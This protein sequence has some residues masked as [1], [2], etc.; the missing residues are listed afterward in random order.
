M[1]EPISDSHP[2]EYDVCLSFSGFD[3]EY[4]DDV[5]KALRRLGVSCF[6]DEFEWENIWGKNLIDE[7][8][9]IYSRSA[10]Y[11][12]IFIS[13]H[14]VENDVW[15]T[16]E[17][18]AAQEADHLFR[19][20]RQYL[21][22]AR[23]DD[24]RLPGLPDTVA[25]ADLRKKTPGEFA[26]M[27]RNRV[28]HGRSGAATSFSPIFFEPSAPSRPRQASLQNISIALTSATSEALAELSDQ[29]DRM[30]RRRNPDGSWDY[31]DNT[32]FQ[33]LYATSS[34]VMFLLQT[35]IPADSD[36]LRPSLALLQS[37][38]K[39]HVDTRAAF[40]ALIPARMAPD[41]LITAFLTHLRGHQFSSG[42][43]QGSF[44]L[45]QGPSTARETDHWQTDNKHRDGASF[46]ACHLSDLLLHIPADA[47]TAR[48]E[49]VSI[50]EGIRGYMERNLRDT[51]YLTDK[52]WKPSPITLFAFA[53]LPRLA[54]D[55]PQNWLA[56]TNDILTAVPGKAP[57]MQA[58]A[59]MNVKYMS[60]WIDDTHFRA[61]AG[62][63]IHNALPRLNLAARDANVSIPDLAAFGRANIYG[64]S[65]LS[66]AHPYH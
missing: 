62:T 21:L 19:R 50:L 39:P 42:P 64:T 52:N 4:V 53:L 43:L 35:G 11:C 54:L 15:T 22:P 59:V 65:F 13:R 26:R 32:E 5:A 9:R 7:L 10:R 36:Q 49:A 6:Y 16:I 8:D 34:A 40:S 45:E 23:F 38:V 37:L 60:D 12:V 30:L 3:R 1:E 63:Y 28:T 44:L 27:I 33:V 66:P 56:V 2:T 18:Q 20:N 47:P 61:L 31:L 14:Y 46:H 48:R 17:R 24:T 29:R 25:Y 57:I 51:G 58:F 41:E 55:L